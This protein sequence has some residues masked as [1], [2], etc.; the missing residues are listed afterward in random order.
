MSLFH[1]TLQDVIRLTESGDV[2]KARIILVNHLAN[3]HHAEN[4]L[5]EIVRKI[6]IYQENLI[7]AKRNLGVKNEIALGHL[8]L[9][10]EALDKVVEST[11]FMLRTDKTTLE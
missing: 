6:H 11:Q 2:D 4:I 1:Q 5:S 8:R 7:L 9:A 3:E 10:Q